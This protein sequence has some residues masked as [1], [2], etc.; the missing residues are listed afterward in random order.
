MSKQLNA[1][2]IGQQMQKLN[3]DFGVPFECM[4]VGG[5]AALVFMGIRESA[6]DVNLWVDSKWFER[7]AEDHKATVHPLKDVV[8]NIEGTEIWVRRYNPYFKTNPEFDRCYNFKVFDVIT[9]IIFY[10]G[11]FMEF[12]RPMPKREEDGKALRALAELAAEKN[13]VL[14]D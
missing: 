3:K 7:L 11:G 13:K 2:Q 12:N 9:L 4:V 5:G 14:V 1:D 6:S 10:R 8:F